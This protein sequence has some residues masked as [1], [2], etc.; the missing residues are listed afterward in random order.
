M[1]IDGPDEQESRLVSDALDESFG[2]ET[3]TQKAAAAALARLTR[4]K[5]GIFPQYQQAFLLSSSPPLLLLLLQ[6]IL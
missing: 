3:K 1:L 4:G 2:G 5:G 6:Y